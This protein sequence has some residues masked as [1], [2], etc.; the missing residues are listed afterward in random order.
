MLLMLQMYNEEV[1]A[2]IYDIIMCCGYMKLFM[3]SLIKKKLILSSCIQLEVVFKAKG[4][5]KETKL[6]RNMS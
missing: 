6:I 1:W 2:S 4:Y 3:L 5:Y